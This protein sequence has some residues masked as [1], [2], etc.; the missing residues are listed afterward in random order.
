MSS[1]PGTKK[2]C[3]GISS[4]FL[5]MEMFLKRF[6]PPCLEKQPS[7]GIAIDEAALFM[8]CGGS[9]TDVV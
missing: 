4:F 6:L 9:A 3:F 1:L 5:L 7:G 8:Q 2:K